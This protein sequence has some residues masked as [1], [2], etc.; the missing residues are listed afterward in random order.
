M[1]KFLF[2]CVALVAFL[3]TNAS[4]YNQHRTD[5]LRTC[6]VQQASP[7]IMPVFIMEAHQTFTPVIVASVP[8]KQLN[9]QLKISDGWRAPFWVPSITINCSDNSIKFKDVAYTTKI[10]IVANMRSGINRTQNNYN[11]NYSYGLRN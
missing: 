1:K 10:P 11:V 6:F 5:Q 3:A 7:Q 8:E 4:G 9:V 2:I